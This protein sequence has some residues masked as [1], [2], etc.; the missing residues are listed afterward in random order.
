MQAG[1]CGH[2]GVVK[3]LVEAEAN[4]GQT[5]EVSDECTES[6][7]NRSIW[8]NVSWLF[9]KKPV[10]LY[11]ACSNTVY[12]C[13]HSSVLFMYT[14]PLNLTCAHYMVNLTLGIVLSESAVGCKL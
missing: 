4:V 7:M 3:A 2:V 12:V 13:V 11:C 10:L 6:V 1:A 8:M 14:L 5:D 9:K